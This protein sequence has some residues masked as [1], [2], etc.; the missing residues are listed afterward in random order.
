MMLAATAAP[1]NGEAYNVASGRTRAIA[2]LA[3]KWFGVCDLTP[4]IAYIGKMRRGDD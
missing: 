4:E 1:G 3:Q 2:E